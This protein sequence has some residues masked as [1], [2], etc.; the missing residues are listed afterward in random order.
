MRQRWDAEQTIFPSGHEK[1]GKSRK[2]EDLGWKKEKKGER[3]EMME[4]VQEVKWESEGK[5]MQRETNDGWM[6]LQL[7]LMMMQ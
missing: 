7:L 5:K 3:I 1:K 4:E 2:Q 6:L